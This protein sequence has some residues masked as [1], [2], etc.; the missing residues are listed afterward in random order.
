MKRYIIISFL[1]LL[2]FSTTAGEKPCDVE[3][4]T[5]FIVESR[6]AYAYHRTVECSAVK[7]ATH[8]VKEVTLDEAIELG[9]SPCK[10]CYK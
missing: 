3:Q 6:Y 4:R 10:I 7:K 1:S 5:V 9:R 8:P 2:Y